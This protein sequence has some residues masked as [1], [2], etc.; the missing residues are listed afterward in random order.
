[1][2]FRDP[3]KPV[4]VY[5][6]MR[7]FVNDVLAD[8]YQ[9]VELLGAGG[10]GYV[11]RAEHLLLHVPVAV[12]V[13]Y[14]S[15]GGDTEHERRFQ[16]EARASMLL[17]HP[18]IVRV[19][20]FGY[21]AESAF[22]VMEYVPGVA[23]DDW[24]NQRGGIPPLEDVS[25]VMQ[26]LLSALDAAHTN[27]IVHR[28]IKPANILIMAEAGA[29]PTAKVVDFGLAHVED[30]EDEGPTLTL[31]DVIAGT[32][33]YMSPEQCRSLAVGPSADLYAAGCVLTTLLQGS[34]P[35]KAESPMDLMAKQMFLP[36]EPLN[37]PPDAEPIPPSLE[38]LRLD[39]L[40]KHV[41]GRP[42]SAA[43]AEELLR[44]AFAET[45]RDRVP[46]RRR[47]FATRGSM[48]P[49]AD[50]GS[51]TLPK[52]GSGSMISVSVVVLRSHPDGW[53]DAN[54]VGISAQNVSVVSISDSIETRPRGDIL[55]VDAGDDIDWALDMVR[56]R[57]ETPVIVC[58]S[59]LDSADLN[60]LI[61]A[62]ASEV[63]RYPI[64]PDMLARRI[65]RVGSRRKQS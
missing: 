48:F 10:M 27:G 54:R 50:P 14:S 53:N 34:P 26:Q 46:L 39:L 30:K 25:R 44:Q 17:N 45:V 52:P 61:E 40:S 33:A 22:L 31:R 43:V 60:R 49:T 58:V 23:L 4:G 19:L 16:R 6:T 62:G 41:H 38:R 15:Q 12:K 65:R 13:L 29:L 8:K 35:F 36:P 55:V 21:H 7:V 51:G 2:A 59:R 32:P 37:R 64:S 1:M 20:D 18:N 3:N 24:V 57:G 47:D 56:A 5:G 9:L 63:L 11:F 42:E 28:D